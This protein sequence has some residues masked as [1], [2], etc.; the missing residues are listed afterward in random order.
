MFILSLVLTLATSVSAATGVT[1]G[2]FTATVSSDGS[3]L[4]SLELQIHL[5]GNNQN[6]I[7]PLPAEAKGITINGKAARTTISGDTRGVKLSSVLGNVTGD[8]N[9]RLQ[10]T[11]PSVV[12]FNDTN[13]LILT[14][15]MLSGFYYPVRDITFTIHIPGD[16]EL[17]PD[18]ISGYYS[19]SIESS[20]SYR[21]EGNSITGTVIKELKDR[22][23]L[24]MTMAVPQ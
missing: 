9:V 13:K 14:L 15:P 11:L 20:L 5:E 17:R 4:V 22:E 6:L 1:G 16:F 3:C 7:F 2:D 19:Q 21:V 8:F 18:F 10:Y 23:T 12:D 24:T